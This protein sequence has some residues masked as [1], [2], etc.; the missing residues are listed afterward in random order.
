L[1]RKPT[2]PAIQSGAAKVGADEELAGP[3]ALGAAFAH[4]ARVNVLEEVVGDEVVA[5][6]ARGSWAERS[7]APAR[8]RPEPAALEEAARGREDEPGENSGDE[9]DDGVLGEQAQADGGADGQPPARILVT[10]QA[11]G[12]VRDQHPPQV[13]EGG[14][15]EL[16][17]SKSGS[18]EKRD[19][20]R[21]GE[22][23][24]ARA[25][26]LARHEPGDND[27][28]SL[29]QHREEPQADHGKAEEAEADAL[30]KR[31]EG[32]IGD[33]S[34][35]EMAGVAEELELVAMKAVAAVG[36]QM[37]KRDG[38]GDGEQMSGVGA[39]RGFGGRL[40]C[41]MEGVRGSSPD[42]PPRAALAGAGAV[43]QRRSSGGRDADRGHSGRGCGLNADS[44]SSKTRQS[45]ARRRGAR[46]RE[47]ASGAAWS[48]RSLQRRRWCRI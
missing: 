47:K 46:R 26:Q 9:K 34:P 11:N 14:V 45:R 39:G 42:E 29:R 25:A 19:G 41:G 16:V 33:E 21:R 18:G 27:G 7:A 8:F 32:R 3:E 2:R 35:V 12:E 37:K 15:L 5:R 44:V 4:V 24:Q 28:R 17:P 1:R 22:L 43:P 31:R 30:D 38:G 10:E 20:E 13:I 40:A 6:R 23:R 36:E 48:A